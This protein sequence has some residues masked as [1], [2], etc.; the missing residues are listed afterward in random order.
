MTEDPR[1]KVLFEVGALL[2]NPDPAKFADSIL[3]PPCAHYGEWDFDGDE[4]CPQPCGQR[5]EWCRA[6]GR[7]MKP[8]CAVLIDPDKT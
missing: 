1:R 5:H 8:P 2:G 4:V 3:A 7:P 6:C